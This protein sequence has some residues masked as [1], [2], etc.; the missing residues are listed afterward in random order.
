[1]AKAFTVSL[2]LQNGYASNLG[3]SIEAGAGTAQLKIFPG[4]QPADPDTAEGATELVAINLP[5]DVFGA[6][7]AGVITGDFVT[8]HRTGISG[9]G[10]SG[11]KTSILSSA[12]HQVNM[13]QG[14]NKAT[15]IARKAGKL[16]SKMVPYAGTGLLLY[17]IKVFN[18]CYKKCNKCKE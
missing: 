11:D 18:N 12:I 8:K 6:P 7:S 13:S 3:D 15:R 2:V 5:T 14:K 1:M 16:V 17:D 4:T 9:G 10:K